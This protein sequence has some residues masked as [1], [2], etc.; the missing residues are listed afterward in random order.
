MPSLAPHALPA[1]SES[2]SD[3]RL[4]GEAVA[5]YNLAGAVRLEAGSGSD[6]TVRITRGGANA[7]RLEV[8]TGPKNGRETLR[9][10]FP[11]DRIL[12]PG[13]RRR[14]GYN[15]TLTVRD[16]GTFG[17]NSG[18]DRA[19]GRRVRIS[20]DGD[21]MEAWADMVISVPAGKRLS[22]HLGVGRADVSNVNGDLLVD[23][24]AASVSAT[25]TRGKLRLDTGSGEVRV[26]DASGEIELDTGSGGVTIER[27]E[28]TRLTVD[29]GSGG[30][31]GTA[32]SADALHLDLGSG[33]TRLRDVR[34]RRIELDSGSGSVDIDLAIDVDDMRVESGSGSV[35]IRVPSS[36]GAQL[37]VDT[38][39]GG[40]ESEV[41]L[42]VRSRSRSALRGSIGDGRGQMVIESGS[43]SVRLL[44]RSGA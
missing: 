40:I 15:T 31:R 13:D 8:E 7:S 10:I 21:G 35:T 38:G 22:M 3:H 9:V 14:N 27:V 17:D 4:S 26:S 1:Q 29:A 34:S 42:T 16:D 39:S 11:D 23:V 37:D 24:A 2:S 12:Y 6:V 18:E 5:I 43:G 44:R 36:L 32:I 25:G 30:L 20:D 41:E 33:S 19:R 28:A